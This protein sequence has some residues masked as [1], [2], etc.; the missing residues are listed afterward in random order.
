MFDFLASLGVGR[1]KKKLSL[2]M[3]TIDLDFNGIGSSLK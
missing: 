1:R 2:L 3:L